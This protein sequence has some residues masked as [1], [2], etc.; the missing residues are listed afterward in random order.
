MS[1]LHLLWG[2]LAC[3]VRSGNAVASSYERAR[4]RYGDKLDPEETLLAK[5]GNIARK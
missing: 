5:E 3:T 1:S 2:S 4:H